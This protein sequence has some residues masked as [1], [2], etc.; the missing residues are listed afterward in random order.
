MTVTDTSDRWPE[1]DFRQRCWLNLAQ[2]L[3]RIDDTGLRELIREA[4]SVKTG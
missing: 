3:L 4:M 2:T 1:Q